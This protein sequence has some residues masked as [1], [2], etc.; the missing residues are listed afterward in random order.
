MRKQ[1]CLSAVLVALAFGLSAAEQGPAYPV[2]LFTDPQRVQRFTSGIPSVDAV[3]RQYAEDN[4]IPGLVWGIVIDGKLVHVN[5]VGV[6]N[7]TTG[8]G[9]T[10]DTVFRIASMTKSFTALAILKLRDSGKLSLEDPVS[11]WIPEFGRMEM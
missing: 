11:R 10:R 5:S 1:G 2:P 4:H 9:V 8:A 3:F 6:R 7:R